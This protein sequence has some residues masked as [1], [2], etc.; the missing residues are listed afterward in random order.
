MHHSLT[1]AKKE[2][3]FGLIICQES[4]VAL[5]DHCCGFVCPHNPR[6]WILSSPPSCRWCCVRLSSEF[7]CTFAILHLPPGLW[8]RL[9]SVNPLAP[10]MCYFLDHRPEFCKVDVCSSLSPDFLPAFPQNMESERSLKSNI[11]FHLC[12]CN[13]YSPSRRQKKISLLG[14]TEHSW[15]N[16]FG[17]SYIFIAV[18]TIFGN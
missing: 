3:A 15:R 18:F 8:N 9:L 1:L 4:T 16:P 17:Y 7:F 14:S 13:L 10:W 6:L 5:S 12:C 11:L 2:K